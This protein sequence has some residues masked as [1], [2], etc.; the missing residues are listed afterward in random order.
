MILPSTI[1]GHHIHKV[2][3]MSEIGETL[4]CEQEQRNHKDPYA[5]SVMKDDTIVGHAPHEK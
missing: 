2:I 1:R 4:H 5:V 3:W